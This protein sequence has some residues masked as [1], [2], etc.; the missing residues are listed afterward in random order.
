MLYFVVKQLNKNGKYEEEVGE[1]ILPLT[2]LHLVG[3]NLC[4]CQSVV[5][6]QI[7]EL[8]NTV[9]LMANIIYI[10]DPERILFL[11]TF[12]FT[13]K[14][15]QQIRIVARLIVIKVLHWQSADNSPPGISHPPPPL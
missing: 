3:A 6:Y 10:F 9:E 8:R 14:Y 4:H 15:L 11:M 13:F 2:Y 5:G 12:R 1:N 7:L